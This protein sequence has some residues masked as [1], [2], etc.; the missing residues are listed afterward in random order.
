MFREAVAAA[1]GSSFRFDPSLD[2]ASLHP[3]APFS[4]FAT[5]RDPPN[6]P[7]RLQGTLAVEFPGLELPL[8]GRGYETPRLRMLRT[9]G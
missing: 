9:E 2:R 5:F 3:P 8:T 1:P 4:G 7:A 6:G